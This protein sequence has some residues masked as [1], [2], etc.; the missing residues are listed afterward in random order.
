MSV[1]TLIKWVVALAMCYFSFVVLQQHFTE[2]KS[3]GASFKEVGKHIG[4]GLLITFASPAGY[5]ILVIAA[6]FLVLS[7][8]DAL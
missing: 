6:V 1:E 5:I 4:I 8:R 2:E 3:W 7:L